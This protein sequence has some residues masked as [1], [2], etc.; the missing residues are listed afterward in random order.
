METLV[1]KVARLRDELT[2]LQAHEGNEAAINQKAIEIHQAE[3]ELKAAQITEQQTTVVNATSQTVTRQYDF[4]V[5]YN[6]IFGTSILNDNIQAL[7]DAQRE[8]LHSY[9]MG[10]QEERDDQIRGLRKE[11]DE[12]N[13][14][15]KRLIEVKGQAELERD[16]FKKRFENAGELIKELQTEVSRLKDREME[17]LKRAEEA[18]LLYPHKVIDITPSNLDAGEAI[19]EQRAKELAAKPKVWDLQWVDELKQTEY[20]GVG[21]DGTELIIKRLELGRYNVQ[22]GPRPEQAVTE[23]V[24]EDVQDSVTQ[25]EPFQ[26][27]KSVEPPTIPM[28]QGPSISGV[29]EAVTKEYIED[30]LAQFASEFGLVKGQVA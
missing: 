15:N 11:V 10:L 1:Q 3:D 22:V 2:A 16:D 12:A 5:D 20:K 13:D 25:E 17:L 7:L 19:R 18:P 4:N 6:D 14:E 23:V 27:V 28:A 9:Y 30:R 29:Q 26:I 21:E 24:A 8:Q